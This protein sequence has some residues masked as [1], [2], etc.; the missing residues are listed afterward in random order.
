MKRAAKAGLQMLSYSPPWPCVKAQERIGIKRES[1]SKDGSGRRAGRSQAFTLVELLVV[2]VILGILSTLAIA[3]YRGYLGDAR[4]SALV[5]QMA[6]MRIFQEDTRLRTGAYGSGTYDFRDAT[7]PILTLTEATGWRPGGN[8][9]TVYVVA[10]DA[11][12]Y[13]VTA[14]TPDGL[15]VTRTFP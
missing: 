13:R 10:A 1:E 11:D 5:Q 15:T 6:A 7:K 14:S 9:Q 3:A 12:G 2:L 4:R 8:E